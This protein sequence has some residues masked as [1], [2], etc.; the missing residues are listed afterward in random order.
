MAPRGGD[1]FVPR[2]W[3]QVTVRGPGRFAT[4]R[5]FRRPTG[6]QV[7]WSSR[8][9]R[10]VGRLAAPGAARRRARP[11]WEAKVLP[12]WVAALFTVGSVFFVTGGVVA[13]ISSGNSSSELYV[14]G[15]GCF[16]VGGYLQVLE[17]LNRP[18]TVVGDDAIAPRLVRRSDE[19]FV[20]M[21]WQLDR[22][23]YRAALV[24]LA[25]ALLFQVNTVFAL[26]PDSGWV[27][28][29]FQVWLP[30]LLGSIGFV[31]SSYLFLAEAGS[32][33]VTWRWDDIGWQ[34]AFLN[35]VGSVGFLVGSFF[36]FFG[37][38]PVR[39]GQSLTTN[40]AILAGSC[41]F[42]AGSV[43][44][45]FELSDRSDDSQLVSVAAAS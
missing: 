34:S 8:R 21:S 36:G 33:Y 29:E 39:I 31:W 43:L 44:M 37:Q 15:A 1:V 13:Y 41:F 28:T 5:V 6:D 40:L 16:T 20:W 10:K 22:L 2:D 30:S 9:A 23:D 27:S 19:R 11:V 45:I 4:E 24:L 17:V 38:G 3:E 12:W 26:F 42:L 14:I 18:R 35:L 25:G 32:E 7:V